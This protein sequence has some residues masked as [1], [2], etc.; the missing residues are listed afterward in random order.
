MSIAFVAFAVGPQQ[1]GLALDH[2]DEVLRIV[3]ITPSTS[4]PSFVEG[5]IN[6]RGVVTPVIDL[7]KRF[8]HEAGPY[9]SSTHIVITRMRGRDTGLI[10]DEVFGVIDGRDIAGD[11]IDPS[12]LLTGDEGRAFDGAQIA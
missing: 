8:G 7:R 9:D 3:A 11:V 10:V 12:T 4:A 5:V 2:V 1:Y 6:R